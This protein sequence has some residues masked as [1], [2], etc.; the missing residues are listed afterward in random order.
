MIIDVKADEGFIPKY[1]H[2][3]DAGADCRSV[4][5]VTIP[6]GDSVLVDLGFSISIPAW[7]VGLLFSRSGLSA[8]YRIEVANGV[9]VIDPG[10]VGRVRAHLV[11][12]SNKSYHI[13]KGDRVAQLVIQRVENAVFSPINALHTTPRGINGFGSTGKD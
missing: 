8:R 3:H 10:Y 11:N 5:S 4:E 7:H 6:P 13:E 12:N 2:V 1:A 9:G